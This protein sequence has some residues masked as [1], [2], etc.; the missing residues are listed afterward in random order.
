VLAIYQPHGYGPTRFL[1]ADLVE[2]F[3]KA[4][5]PR[6]RL[7]MLEVFYAGGTATRDFSARDLVAEIAARGTVAE[8][9]ESRERLIER[10]AAE[11]RPGDLVL[12]MGARD[13]SLTTLA[14]NLVERLGQAAVGGARPA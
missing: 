13:P 7:W 6:D 5:G 14:R 9:A 3:A 1:R 8:F 10:V 2:V 4:L 12:V 11:A